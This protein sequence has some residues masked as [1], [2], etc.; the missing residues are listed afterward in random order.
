MSKNPVVHF[1]M[2]YKDASRVTKFYQDAFGWGMN[3][4]GGAMGN[5]VVAQ[6]APTDD[7]NM[8]TAP[9]TI[10]GGFFQ[11]D[12]Q[13]PGQYPSVVI[14]VEDIQK[15]MED[16]KNAGGE[17]YGE[18]VEIPGIGTYVAFS[19]SEGNRISLLQPSKM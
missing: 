5:Y 12:P 11:F 8:V 10:N 16:V 13:K 1:E 4:M 14:A 9:G 19:D 6:T 17:V 7:N 2:P 15:A 3:T 18:P